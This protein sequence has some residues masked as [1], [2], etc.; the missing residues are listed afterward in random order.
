MTYLDTE[1]SKHGGKPTELYKFEGTYAN[2]FYTSGP[3]K[4][5]YPDT[6]DGDTYL[7]IALSR[8]E[9]NCG[10]QDDDGLDLTI[11]MS[12]SNSLV[13]VY[14]FQ[15]SP[16][17]LELTIFRFHTLADVTVYWTGP[18]NDIQVSNGIATIKS[19]STLASS[20]DTNVPNF[21]FQSPCNNVLFDPRCK[22]LEA[23]WSDS[24][25]VLAIN[26]RVITVDS[27]GTFAA[28][29]VGGEIRV[30]S[31]E[32]RMITAQGP[33]VIPV[34]GPDPDINAFEIFVNFP[35]SQMEVGDIID[36]TVGCDLAYTGDCRVKF[37]N[38]RNFGGFPFIPAANP[39]QDGIDAANVPLPDNTC[40]PTAEWTYKL[41]FQKT[42]TLF[43]GP[44]FIEAPIGQIYYDVPSESLV[45]K[46]EGGY[47]NYTMYFYNAGGPGH[48]KMTCNGDISSFDTAE[49]VITCQ[50][51]GFP[52][53]V[54]SGFHVPFGYYSHIFEWDYI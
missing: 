32:R 52:P 5:R 14:G 7:P 17:S 22:L 38:N 18:V 8:S 6:I 47:D 30:A 11:Q 51:R 42:G 16:P 31:G 1:T 48:W 46:T 35:F 4:V 54:F 10:T 44:S 53:T 43:I 13:Q 49:V 21:Y 33:V 2:F 37:N 24:A 9:I 29:L 45:V 19:P 26:G 3:K 25:E 50:K 34:P 15:T 20:L 27:V 36:F 40:L 12:V 23:D 39:F 28:M 41:T